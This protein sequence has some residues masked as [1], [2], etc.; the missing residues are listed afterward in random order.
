MNSKPDYLNSDNRN[1]DLKSQLKGQFACVRVRHDF[2]LDERGHQCRRCGL[3]EEFIGNQ[4]LVI[5]PFASVNEVQFYG[6]TSA[7]ITGLSR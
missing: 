5:D 2:V 7:R 3:R 4:K 6:P 1:P